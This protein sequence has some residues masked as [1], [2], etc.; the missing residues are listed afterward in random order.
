M[1]A[2]QN[3]QGR[4]PH[5]RALCG[6]TGPNVTREAIR[7]NTPPWP[8]T[9]THVHD[10]ITHRKEHASTQRFSEEVGK[11]VDGAHE[12]T[13]NLVLFHK[14]THEEVTTFDVFHPTVVLRVV[15]HIDGRLVV[16]E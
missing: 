1:N 4:P 5:T 13:P 14:L 15:G 16:N 7:Y 11:I 10:P 12:W 3:R 2:L 8:I 9:H 6:H